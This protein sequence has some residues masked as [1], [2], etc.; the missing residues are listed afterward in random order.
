MET[1]KSTAITRNEI[2]GNHEQGFSGPYLPARKVWERYGVTSVSLH[3]WLKNPDMDFP[4]P[5]YIG[6][7]R[8]WKISEI[9]AWE[10]KAHLLRGE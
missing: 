1:I 8:Y 4:K 10:Q 3:R 6:R 5:I 9:E 2:P 7:F